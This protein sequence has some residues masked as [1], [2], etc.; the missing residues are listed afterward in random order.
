MP[1]SVTS[2]DGSIYNFQSW[3]DGDVNPRKTITL[4]ANK[5]FIAIYVKNEPVYPNPTPIPPPATVTPYQWFWMSGTY[6]VIAP[7]FARDTKNYVLDH[8]EVS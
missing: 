8:W 3:N 5:G 4:D 2:N 1:L 7:K 6:Q